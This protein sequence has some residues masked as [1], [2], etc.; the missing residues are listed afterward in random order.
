M[1]YLTLQPQQSEAFKKAMQAADWP[2]THQD[3]GQTE[4]LA[5]GYVVVWQKDD[6]KVMLNYED[7]QGQERVSLEVTPAIGDEIQGLIN[8]L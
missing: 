4:I 2:I 3:V 7:R 6:N 5:Y 1:K 8:A